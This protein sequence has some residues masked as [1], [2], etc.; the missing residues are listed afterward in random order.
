[1]K[2]TLLALIVLGQC[3]DALTF[4]LFYRVAPVLTGPSEKNWIIVAAL[5]IGGLAGVVVLKVGIGWVTFA[6]G[7]FG[8]PTPAAA[9][10]LA[11]RLTPRWASWLG[12]IT[13]L[14][15]LAFRNIM[16][17]TATASGFVGACFNT[18][19]IWQVLS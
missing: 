4:V 15:R 11:V 5:G 10:R 18:V 2:R 9:G 14:H 16:L 13:L 19:A 12:R 6:V 17:V 8:V 1:M 7:T 3:L